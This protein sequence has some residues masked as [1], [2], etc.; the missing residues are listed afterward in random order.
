MQTRVEEWL[1]PVIGPLYFHCPNTVINSQANLLPAGSSLSSI[2]FMSGEKKIMWGFPFVCL[3]KPNFLGDS[4][5]LTLSH[6]SETDKE[7]G[8]TKEYSG[9]E[10]YS[11]IVLVYI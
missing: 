6:F 7:R 11:L 5:I 1:C 8:P 2:P 3:M 9:K 4:S 10:V